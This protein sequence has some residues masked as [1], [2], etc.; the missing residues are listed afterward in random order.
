MGA[1][2]DRSSPWTNLPRMTQPTFVPIAEADQ[3]RPARHLHV[4]GTWTTTRPAELVGARR[5]PWAE[6]R[7]RRVPTRA[8]LSGWPGVRARASSSARVS[9]STTSCSGR[10]SSA[11][12]RA[13]LF[14]RAPSIY[15]VRLA[16]NLWRF[17]DADAPAELRIDAPGALLLDLP[18]L[19]RPA[20]AGRLGPRRV[21][22]LTPDEAA[23]RGGCRRL[24]GAR[25]G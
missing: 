17:L 7:A 23:G 16:L 22:R 9:R 25:A 14:G 19:R 5:A 1:R 18:R 8:S 6:R 10:P 13:A 11:A 24:G 2:W 12:K 21:M 20:G 4:P 3:V 15:D